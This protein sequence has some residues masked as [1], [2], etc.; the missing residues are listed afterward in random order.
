MF[1]NRLSGDSK[2]ILLTE[3]NTYQHTTKLKQA[4]DDKQRFNSVRIDQM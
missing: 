3:R 1:S 4:N 2:N